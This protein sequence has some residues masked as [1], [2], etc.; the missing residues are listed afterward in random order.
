M[1]TVDD[2]IERGADRLE[3]LVRAG[4]RAGGVKA[5]VARM[6]ADDPEF[7]RKLKPSL[8]AA[9]ARGDAPIGEEP[10]HVD[11][12]VVDAPKPKSGGPSPFVVIA[13]A[14]ALGLAL[15]HVVDWLG[16]RYPRD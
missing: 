7:L 5:K 14:F 1:S 4:S 13:A 8:I 3:E 10:T 6:F 15:A 2:K 16:H 9:R 12:P 11:T